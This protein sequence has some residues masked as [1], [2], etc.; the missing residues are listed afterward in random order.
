MK[1]NVLIFGLIFLMMISIGMIFA[2]SSFLKNALENYI[3]P[4]D[5]AVDEN[6]NG[7]VLVSGESANITTINNESKIITIYSIGAEDIG[8]SVNEV[9]DSMKIGET[10]KIDNLEIT[11]VNHE[12]V[13]DKVQVALIIGGV[14]HIELLK[15]FKIENC[16]DSDGLDPKI[17]GSISYY[18][19]DYDYNG[20][21]EPKYET[22]EDYCESIYSVVE[23][24]CGENSNDN[25]NSLI[26]KNYFCYCNEGICKGPAFGLSEGF[27]RFLR[28]ESAKEI[29]L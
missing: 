10:K 17:K 26:M 8:I 22:H 29:S 5:T 6:R 21:Q 23:Y 24:Y 3:F 19:L 20:L 18:P 27:A 13:Y 11:Y 25:K 9:G 2:E 16:Q 4:N 7:F 12:G 14:K 1:K 15:Y 28:L